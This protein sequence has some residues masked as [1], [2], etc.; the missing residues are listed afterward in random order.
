MPSRPAERIQPEVEGET[1][2][3]HCHTVP[4][5]QASLTELV[6]AAALV[7]P[8]HGVVGSTGVDVDLVVLAVALA[9]GEAVGVHIEIFSNPRVAVVVDF[10]TLFVHAAVDVGIGVVAVSVAVGVVAQHPG[11]PCRL[12]RDHQHTV[13]HHDGIGDEV[14]V[15]VRSPG[16][17]VE[18]GIV[19]TDAP[20]VEVSVATDLGSGAVVVIVRS[21]HGPRRAADGESGDQ[22]QDEG[23]EDGLDVG[24]G[25]SVPF[26]CA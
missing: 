10:V 5:R 17:G 6:P 1:A 26:G 2:L 12:T 9:D 19:N 22:E 18:D 23:E 13:P 15:A 7:F 11:R 16:V 21:G 24:A 8:G 25:H 14:R 3:V 20:A 4:Q